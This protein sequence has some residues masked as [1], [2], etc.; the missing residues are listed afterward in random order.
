[1]H[2]ADLLKVVMIARS[3]DLR[4]ASNID[5]AIRQTMSASIYRIYII[6]HTQY[7]Y[8][9]RLSW[10]FLFRLLDLVIV[11]ELFEHI[12]RVIQKNYTCLRIKY[13][14]EDSIAS[15]VRTGQLQG[16]SSELI[17]TNLKLIV[18]HQ[19]IGYTHNF[20]VHPVLQGEARTSIREFI[21]QSL[22]QTLR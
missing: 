5:L 8:I 7:N 16:T 1:M 10:K 17:I 21:A 22:Q 4:P 11:F 6:D 13:P 19:N 14:H 3:A 9:N 20:V 12:L 2:V 15:S 18:I